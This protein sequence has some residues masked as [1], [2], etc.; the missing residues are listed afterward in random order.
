[1]KI[2]LTGRPADVESA[3]ATIS[4]LPG[5]DVTEISGPYPKCGPRRLVRVY[6][7]IRLMNP[8]RRGQPQPGKEIPA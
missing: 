8:P 7:D 4:A 1:M 3:V 2:R 6:L 5:F